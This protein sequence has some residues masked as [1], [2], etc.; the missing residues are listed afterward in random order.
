MPPLN[1]L[2]AEYKLKWILG[3]QVTRSVTVLHEITA[4]S[5][6]IEGGKATAPLNIHP[7]YRTYPDV[8]PEP[9]LPKLRD[10]IRFNP[11][12]RFLAPAPPCLNNVQHL[13]FS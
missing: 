1:C 6:C 4:G 7:W 10:F 12:K 9:H 3:Y 8:L 2:F 13:V 11:L 5:V